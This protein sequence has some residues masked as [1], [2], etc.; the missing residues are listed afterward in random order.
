MRLR[1]NIT[2]DDVKCNCGCGFDSVSP[3]VLDV[4]QDVRD[5]FGKPI[6]INSRGHCSCRCYNHNKAV[7]GVDKSKHLPNTFTHSSRAIDFEIEDVTPT[8]I[9][10]YLDQKYP[11]CLGIGL[12]KTF[13]HIDDRMDQAYRWHG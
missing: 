13:V 12:Y 10:M 3:A 1:K 9:Y 4:A 11:S 8:E 2:I 5:H 6:H 7:G